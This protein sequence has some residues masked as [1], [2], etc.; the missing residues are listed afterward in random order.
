MVQP[1]SYRASAKTASF[2]E[3][4]GAS[5]GSFGTTNPHMT[6]GGSHSAS[7]S[8]SEANAPSGHRPVHRSESARTAAVE[9]EPEADVDIVENTGRWT[10]EE[11]NMFLDGLKVHGKGWKQIAQM[12]K[13]RTVVQI[14][15]HAQKY[16]QKLSKAQQNG[17]HT[18][19][20]MDTRSG[21]AT[22]TSTLPIAVQPAPHQKK[23]K[24]TTSKR[25]AAANNTAVSM[26]AINAMNAAIAN[27]AKSTVTVKVLPPA[28][29]SSGASTT[30]KRVK[31]APLELEKVPR[32]L[33]AGHPSPSPNSVMEPSLNFPSAVPHN[34]YAHEGD[35]ENLLVGAEDNLDWFGEAGD[36]MVGATSVSS[37]ASMIDSSDMSSCSS[38]FSGNS[39]D[40]EKAMDSV[41]EFLEEPP[42][43]RRHVAASTGAPK[44]ADRSGF[45]ESADGF[46]LM[47]QSM[48]DHVTFDEDAF[49]SALLVEGENSGVWS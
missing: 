13:T 25:K 32:S 33:A 17:N 16:F 30:T 39:S 11:H 49:V 21:P 14:R 20:T 6:R 31:V 40:S 27:Q 5:R 15:T 36:G 1:E 48:F 37:M 47:D 38:D 26:N 43:K 29:A 7:S 45:R 19:V 44:E 46:D 3:H 22:S 4:G 35:V 9:A 41:D 42:T 10:M 18:E 23:K 12:I 2:G 28:S 8:A 24:K 34:Y